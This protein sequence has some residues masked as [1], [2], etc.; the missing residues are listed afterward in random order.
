MGI[1]KIMNRR[2]IMKN[3]RKT[4][5]LTSW[6][7]LMG[8]GMTGCSGNSKV[9]MVEPCGVGYAAATESGHLYVWGAFDDG[10]FGKEFEDFTKPKKI[11]DANITKIDCGNGFGGALSED[12]TLYMWGTNGSGQLAREYS[13]GSYDVYD[14]GIDTIDAIPVMEN[15]VSFACSNVEAAA[16]T[17]EGELY[18]WGGNQYEPRCLLS[19]VTSVTAHKEE[20]VF[21]AITEDGGLYSW[22]D[23]RV[24]AAI[25]GIPGNIYFTVDYPTRILDDVVEVVVGKGQG[26]AAAITSDGSLYTWGA[27]NLGQIGNGTGGVDMKYDR[28]VKVMEQIVSVALGYDYTVA[29]TAD[30]EMYAWGGNDYG[31]F[32]NGTTEHSWMPVKIM[33]DVMAISADQFNTAIIK[34][35]GTM[36][37]C[38]TNTYGQLGNAE[39]MKSSSTPV[40]VLDDVAAVGD[41]CSAITQSGKLYV[42]GGNN[43]GQLGNGKTEDAYYKAKPTRVKLS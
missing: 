19:G 2:S 30:G 7:L 32:G 39:T 8:Y 16:V 28:P 15:V 27:N 26:H 6:I 11:L 20:D 22:G 3:M 29:L 38:G 37:M 31:T 43:H 5:V 13:G 42:W 24:N 9:T 17:E 40:K 14:E 35:D 18:Q 41:A 33:D 1:L 12:G 34:T 25:F 21:F 36:Y 23:S 10:Y 4:A